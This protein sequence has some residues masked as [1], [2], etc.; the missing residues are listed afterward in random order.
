MLIILVFLYD[1]LCGVRAAF[2]PIF[3]GCSAPPFGIVPKILKL[4]SLDAV[5]SF[6][7]VGIWSAQQPFLDRF[8]SQCVWES[9][10]V[11]K[12]WPWWISR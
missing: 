1:Y 2:G 9:F 7:A 11:G 4:V 5:E 10:V 8:P 3:I 12:K 6:L